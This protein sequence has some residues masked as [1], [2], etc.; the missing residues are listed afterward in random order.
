MGDRKRSLAGVVTFLC[1]LLSGN[2]AWAACENWAAKI[3]SVQGKVEAKRTDSTQWQAVKLDD[4]FCPGD[5]IRVSV[6]SRAA[7]IL[8]NET[9]LR[10]DQNSAIKL[11]AVNAKEPSI[12]ELLK[13]IGHFISRVPRSLKVETPSMNAA[14]EGTEFVVAVDTNESRVTVF[15]GTVLASNPIGKLRV[16]SG[17]SAV[18]GKNTAPQMGLLAKPRD[19]VQWA[20]Y[21]PPILDPGLKQADPVYRAAALLNSGRV[22]EATQILSKLIDNGQAMALQAIIAIIQNHKQ[23][24]LQQAQRAILLAPDSAAPYI[25]L[26]YAQQA[27]FDLDA[28]LASADLATLKEHGSALAWARLAELQLSS[29]DL[30][31]ALMSAKIAANLN[32]ELSRAQTVLGYA[33]LL[34]IDI[35]AA[36]QAFNQA[37]TLDQ[38]DPLPRLGLGLAKIRRNELADGRREIEIAASLDPNN[39]I[40]RSYLGKAYFEEKRSPLD[41]EQFD[42]AKALDPR[43][44]TPWF[45]DA[46]AMQSENRPVEALESLQKSIDLNDNRAVYRSS[47]QLDQDNAA[48]G[49]SQ[50]RI[51][52][53]LGF[54]Q[55][56]L[57]QAYSSLT[58]DPANHSAHRL[59]ADAYAA[60]PRHEIARVSELLQ[61]QLLQP[62]NNNPIQPQLAE[63]NLGILD[64]AGPSDMSPSEFNPMFSR[65]RTTFQLNAIKGS[66]KTLGNDAVVSGMHDIFSYS[67]S[68]FHFET[69]GF[70]PN[71][72]LKQDIYDLFIQTRVSDSTSI[73]AQYREQDTRSG[74]LLLRFDPDNY[75]ENQRNKKHV[76]NGRI[77]FRY[78]PSPEHSL[79]WSLVRSEQE[80]SSN[81][82]E[83]YPDQPG[84]GM[85]LLGEEFKTIDSSA[86][87]N[88]IQYLFNSPG[89]KLVL[90]LG[91]TE[92]NRAD[93]TISQGSTLPPLDY[94]IVF[95]EQESLN[96]DSNNSNLYIYS[97]LQ[98]FSDL[99]VTLGVSSDDYTRNVYQ[100][101]GMNPKL[102]I[103]F[104]LQRNTL[105]RAAAFSTIKRP[106][107]ANQTIEPTQVA[108]FNQFFDDPDG[109]KTER[110]G[111][112]LEHKFSGALYGGIETSKRNVEF[113]IVN[114]NTGEISFDDLNE[115]SR[116]GYLYWTINPELVFSTEYFHEEFDSKR[117]AP[118][119][120][121]TNR[122]PLGFSYNAPN[123]FGARFYAIYV[124][125]EYANNNTVSEDSFWLADTS[126]SFRLPAR[127]G[128][129]IIGVKNLFDKSFNYYDVDYSGE[130]GP[131]L[132]QPDRFSYAKFALSF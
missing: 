39:S 64:G 96:L 80:E 47:L 79:I 113:P 33:H 84:P 74:D 32:P 111:I 26:S 67:I 73:Q 86:S 70:R 23:Q 30:D 69:D 18:A 124:K 5:H 132:F 7:I 36:M 6:N 92:I 11:T 62:L 76:Q 81:N 77:G 131:P 100:T 4:T 45:Y 58:H 51:Y 60:I 85:D 120:L 53:N 95:Y 122:I 93:I 37:I 59:L 19:A 78:Q 117:L 9:L 128:I 107:V 57:Q 89:L 114:T 129:I 106:L 125:Q 24:A 28:A 130:P 13:G 61:S 56:A 25:A 112:A 66:N 49:A 94:T 126:L 55:L 1:L 115:R 52:N 15:E 38:T 116:R 29:G 16:T 109:S 104:N 63:S 43:D 97:N 102:G 22:D 54:E 110:Y 42:M 99:T 88:E 68:Q 103:L 75:Q 127:A 118:E 101:D 3:A 20:L 105:L 31:E 71:N 83:I 108:G 91:Q 40:V 48:R 35:D 98:L 10:L 12:I 2:T 14:I 17:E 121:K 27:S 46:I 82:S 8:V 90:G 87:T 44:P 119:R 123:G 34:Q 72:D 50:A 21:Y 65:N 41:T